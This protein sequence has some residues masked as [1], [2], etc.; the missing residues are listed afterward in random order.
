MPSDFIEAFFRDEPEQLPENS[1]RSVSSVS[2][3][4]L[5][6][7]QVAEA[8][9]IAKELVKLRDAG[10]ISGAPD[11]P[12]ARFYAQVIHTFE[13]EFIG[14]RP[15]RSSRRRSRTLNEANPAARITSVVETRESS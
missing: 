12:E 13:G 7:E 3:Q 11:D 6:P 5:S 9:R 2:E 1:E 8:E 14:R 15:A 4:P 10:A